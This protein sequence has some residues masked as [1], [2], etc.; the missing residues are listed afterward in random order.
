MMF[1]KDKI[2]LI[3]G[4][5]SGIGKEIAVKFAHKGAKVVI[6]DIDEEKAKAT[7]DEILKSQHEAMAV[8]L[9]VTNE[10]H[11]EL[12]VA[13]VIATYGG[14][15]ILVSNAGTQFISPIEELPFQEWKKL[16]CLTA[17]I[18]LQPDNVIFITRICRVCMHPYFGNHTPFILQTYQPVPFSLL[19][20][21]NITY[22]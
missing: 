19:Q 18:I 17:K 7:A 11:V 20:P 3:T 9:D 8:R 14:I 10:E 22:L 12:A 6:A 13:K 4:A 16:T 15:D 21:Y 1:L 2:A 5:A